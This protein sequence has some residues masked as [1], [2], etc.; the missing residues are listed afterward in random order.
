MVA[1]AEQRG[2]DRHDGQ[3]EP[4]TDVQ[5]NSPAQP[6]AQP[7]DEEQLR[8]FQQFQQFQDYLKFSEAQRQGGGGLTP[9][10]PPP[11]PPIPQQ[12]WQPPTTGG[13]HD[14]VTTQPPKIKAPRWL[15][16][17]AGKILGWI[18]FLV[19]LGLA[20]NWGYNRLFPS[21]ANDDRPAA[22][23]G[24]GKYH[25]NHV[26]SKQPFEAVRMVYQNVANGQ[27]QDG[28]GRFEERVQQKFADDLGF[29]DC[30]EAILGLHAKVTAKNAY[31]ESMPSSISEPIPGDVFVISSCRFGIRGGPALGAFQVSKVEGG[32]WLITG[33]S[34]EPDPCPAPSITPTP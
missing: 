12:N 8:Q 10:E 13:S 23:T 15:K 19:I 14:L 24:G 27:V 29:A 26:F 5:R 32:Q 1:V 7:M 3:D 18:I 31:A 25:T 20:L 17:L 2:N 6:P 4:G 30:R 28:C 16:R 9:V 21:T 11:G 34:N 33:H 22:E